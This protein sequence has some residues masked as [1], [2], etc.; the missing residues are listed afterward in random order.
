MNKNIISLL[1][2][3][4]SYLLI[5]GRRLYN[6]DVIRLMSWKG[7]YLYRHVLQRAASNITTRRLS[8]NTRIGST[9]TVVIF[10]ST[11]IHSSTIQLK[12]WKGDFLGP[13]HPY[14]WIT[15]DQAHPGTLWEVKWNGNKV[16]NCL[17]SR[18]VLSWYDLQK[19]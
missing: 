13:S 4:Y 18:F 6:G 12:S 17:I 10:N 9:W 15:T 3:L 16:M 19:E 11:Q 2:K 7:D 14:Q 1:L 5:I 8:N